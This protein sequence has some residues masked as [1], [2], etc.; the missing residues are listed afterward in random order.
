[1]S[2]YILVLLLM[3]WFSSNIKSRARRMR[4]K[5]SWFFFGRWAPESSSSQELES[6]QP[7][8]QLPP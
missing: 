7:A 3:S 8:E 1:M 6:C 4:E 5:L 2:Y